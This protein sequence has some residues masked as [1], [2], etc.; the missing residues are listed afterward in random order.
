MKRRDINKRYNLIEAESEN[1]VPALLFDD[2]LYIVDCNSL[3]AEKGYEKFLGEHLGKFMSIHA[4]SDISR[5]I[6]MR[7][8]SFG[9]PKYTK[10]KIHG[11]PG[12]TCALIGVKHY[13]GKKF[14]ELRVYRSNAAMLKHTSTVEF[15][16][17]EPF[18]PSDYSLDD[19]ELA[20][21]N[22]NRVLAFNKLFNLYMKCCC[23]ERHCRCFDIVLALE[24]TVTEIAYRVDKIKSD[25]TFSCEGRKPFVCERMDM[26][27]YINYIVLILTLIDSISLNRKIKVHA[28]C[29]GDDMLTVHFD[30]L[31]MKPNGKGKGSED[32]QMRFPS[33][34]TLYSVIEYMSYIFD[35]EFK[36]SFDSENNLHGELTVEPSVTDGHV[37]FHTPEETDYQSLI[38]NALNFASFFTSMQNIK[39]KE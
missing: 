15:I 22:I 36:I 9:M 18:L 32:I 8:A 33:C 5:F 19:T 23:A 4:L 24:S 27:D 10:Q 16:M 37:N 20:A 7:D 34:N 28:D 29:T 14:G 30:T 21:D 31:T 12:G 38:S 25:I 26:N 13:F 17:P 3:A 35:T 2:K 39:E 1:D 6:K 11:I